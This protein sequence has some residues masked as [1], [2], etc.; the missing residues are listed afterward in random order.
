M[1]GAWEPRPFGIF[2]FLAVT[3]Q[4]LA[5]LTRPSHF[6]RLFDLVKSGSLSPLCVPT[7]P[8]SDFLA[9]SGN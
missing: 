1:G 3:L 5:Y 8:Y 2:G 9:F 7:S 4:G 6:V